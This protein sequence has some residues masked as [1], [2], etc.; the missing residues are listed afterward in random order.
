MNR[1]P[2]DTLDC[3]LLVE[4][5]DDLH[6]VMHICNRKQPVGEFQILNKEGVRQLLDSIGLEVRQP[7]REAI[8]IIVD[9]N[10]APSAHWDAVTDRLRDHGFTVPRTPDRMGTIIPETEENRAWVSG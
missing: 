2:S 6:M 9:A 5:G 3:V 10:S 7:G 1:Y 8:G 4:G